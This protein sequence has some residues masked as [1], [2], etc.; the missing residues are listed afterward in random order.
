V[1]L[2]TDWTRGPCEFG[3]GEI[4]MTPAPSVTLCGK[5]GT[6]R[7]GIMWCEV[8]ACDD[9]YARWLAREGR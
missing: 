5:P 6:V 2:Q 9:C 1:R 8:Y 7:R 3:T 4:T